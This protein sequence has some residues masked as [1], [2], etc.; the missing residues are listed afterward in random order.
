MLKLSRIKFG[1]RLLFSALGI[2]F[3]LGGI[4]TATKM[5]QIF[6]V[7]AADGDYTVTVSHSDEPIW[8][9]EY[10]HQTNY[11]TV[12]T[13]S[14]ENTTGFCAMPELVNNIPDGTEVAEKLNSTTMSNQE[15]TLL[16]YAYNS[17]STLARAFI[18]ELYDWLDSEASV[19]AYVHAT[20]GIIYSGQETGLGDYEVDYIVGNEDEG[21]TGVIEKLYGVITGDSEYSEYS[22]LWQDAQNYSL[23]R[24][25]DTETHADPEDALQEVVWIEYD[26]PQFGNIIVHKCDIERESSCNVNANSHSPSGGGSLAGITFYLYDS[27]GAKIAEA[28]TNSDGIA[29]FSDLPV[30]TN[31][32]V[33]EMSPNSSY[34]IPE[35]NRR[36]V[37]NLTTDGAKVAFSDYIKRSDISFTKTDDE[38]NPMKN[39]AFALESNKTH[40]RHILV[41]DSNGV[42]N[43]ASISHS[44]DTNGYDNITGGNYIYRGYGTWFYGV[45]SG[46]PSVEP[47]W[48]EW[49]KWGALPYDTYTLT[50]LECDANKYCQDKGVI[51]N[52]ISV[53]EDDT[54]ITLDPIINNCAEFGISTTAT[55]T[56]DGDKFIE[57]S[58][59]ASITDTI[60]YCGEAGLTY[61]IQGVLMDKVTGEAISAVQEIPA[62]LP[63]D[64][65]CGTATMTFS[66]DA[67]EL[68]G[69]DIVV[70]ETLLYEDEEVA[71]HKDL[72]DTSQTVTVI[73][74]GTTAVDA[75]DG[76]KLVEA[77]EDSQIVDTIDYCLKAGLEYT[78]S[79][80]LV[81]K[82]T[83]E[84]ITI[85]EETVEETI[86]FIPSTNCGTTQM[87]FTLDSSELAGKAIVVYESVEYNDNTILEHQD[88]NDA[89]QTVNII[90]LDTYALDKSDEDKEVLATADATVTDHIK[91]CLVAGTEYTILG[92]LMNKQTGEPIVVKDALV[93][94]ST[95][96]TPTENCGD[97]Y[98]DFDFD[99]TGMGGTE[100]VVFEKAGITSPTQESD[101][102]I[103]LEYD[104][105]SPST[106][107]SYFHTII[108][109]EN[110]DDVDQTVLVTTPETPPKSSDTGRLTAAVDSSGGT[111]GDIPL[112]A[113]SIVVVTAGYFGIR[114]FSRKRFFGK[115]K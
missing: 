89:A 59:T 84:P 87:T 39:V 107:T 73:S 68:A 19:Y 35:D 3:L 14:G 52:T 8:Y 110:I 77:S 63:A 54:M 92:T 2:I 72:N 104:T 80:V 90:S 45:T 82:A 4:F 74:L 91:Y 24:T 30:G 42:V 69:H 93:R 58:A 96:L 23:Y 37:N 108:S 76:D 26:A 95:T 13:S 16:I 100:I 50:E 22:S 6:K 86:T 36:T 10:G 21:I 43:T 12:T 38:G 31:Y 64:S 20:I 98:L 46:S 85:D 99:A 66:L 75:A 102:D 27:N 113:A 47:D 44:T 62:P 40:E 25:K 109:H 71:E 78:I 106:C 18:S 88:L 1:K 48:N 56:A 57:A 105:E 61:T 9:G 70:F 51:S 49:N 103:C 7:N 15:I 5:V 114:L 32:E 17:N 115:V 28:T 41:T 33:R 79:G 97:L 81:D 11:Y 83:G 67:S 112:V 111:G 65:D 94:S 60:N 55:D 53:T 101:D 34:I 29:T